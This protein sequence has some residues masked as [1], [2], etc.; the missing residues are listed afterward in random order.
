MF[1]HV[2]NVVVHLCPKYFI[3]EIMSDVPCINV[4]L[5]SAETEKYSQ[6]KQRKCPHSKGMCSICP[7]CLILLSNYHIVFFIWNSAYLL[8]GRLVTS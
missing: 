1:I 4:I 5:F 8:E 2:M 6:K 3:Y 7:T